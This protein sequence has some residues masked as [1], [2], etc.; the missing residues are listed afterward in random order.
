MKI[1]LELRSVQPLPQ[2]V[3]DCKALCRKKAERSVG[4]KIH[5]YL[6]NVIIQITIKSYAFLPKRRRL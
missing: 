1:L 3:Y 6:I 4:C 2:G 5:C